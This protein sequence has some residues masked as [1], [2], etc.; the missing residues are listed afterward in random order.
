MFYVTQR[1]AP[2][3]EDA[4]ETLGAV[5]WS[6][7]IPKGNP[8]EVVFLDPLHPQELLLEAIFQTCPKRALIVASLKDLMPRPPRSNDKQMEHQAIV[9]HM[10]GLLKEIPKEVP[11]MLI[12]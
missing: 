9:L 4:P 8:F 11:G 3:P 6:F 5:S 2:N 12:E 1:L 7:Q 10:I